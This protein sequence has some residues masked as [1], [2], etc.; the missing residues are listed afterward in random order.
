MH[1]AMTHLV[2]AEVEAQVAEE[3]VRVHHDQ[4]H[5]ARGAHGGDRRQAC[6]CHLG[7]DDEGEANEELR[8]RCEDGGDVLVH[9]RARHVLVQLLQ[10]LRDGLRAR[11]SQA[12][13]VEEEV[14]AEVPD[15]DGRTVDD[16]E[17]ADACTCTRVARISAWHVDGRGAVCDA[18]RRSARRAQALTRQHEVLERLGPGGAA[19]DEADRRVFHRGLAMLTP[20][21]QLPVVAAALRVGLVGR[22]L[23]HVALC[24]VGVAVSVEDT[25]QAMLFKLEEN[26]T[27][28]CSDPSER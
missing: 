1:A 4:R 9:V 18:S 5:L 19:V 27:T 25:F 14:V 12:L 24:A 8:A 15:G 11:P 21:P 22:Q 10:Q 20:E 16:G 23:G 13:G 28:T 2:L 7:G 6:L 3:A 26:K 17:G